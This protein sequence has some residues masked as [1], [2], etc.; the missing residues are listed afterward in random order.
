MLLAS[1]LVDTLGLVF[2]FLILFPALVTGLIIFAVAQGLGE[3]RANQNYRGAGRRG[4]DPGQ[5]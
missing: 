2:V 3:R 4:Q 1:S 5:G